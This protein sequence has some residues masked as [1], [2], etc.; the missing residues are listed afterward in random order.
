MYT[1]W[2]CTTIGVATLWNQQVKTD[3]T[4]P[5]NKLDIIIHNNKKKGTYIHI[6]R[7]IIRTSWTERGLR[8]E[9][10]GSSYAIKSKEYVT[11][12]HKTS[13]NKTNNNDKI[14]STQHFKATYALRY[15]KTSKIGILK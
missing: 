14:T 13:K 15:S 12:L 9:R 2:A 6:H 5:S 8:A 4:I 10:N 3:R 1:G 11:K 7:S